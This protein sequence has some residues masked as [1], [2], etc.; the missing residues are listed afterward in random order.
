M[1]SIET[2]LIQTILLNSITPK[3]TILSNYRLT[4]LLDEILTIVIQ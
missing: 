1:T 4:I 2:E 3:S